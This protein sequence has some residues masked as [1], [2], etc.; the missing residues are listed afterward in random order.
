MYAVA[1]LADKTM[2]Y[3]INGEWRVDWAGEYQL[4]DVIVVYERSNHSADDEHVSLRQTPVDL[5]VFV[6][7]LIHKQSINKQSDGVHITFTVC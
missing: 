4:N 5:N 2:S 3:V 7:I 6:S 1:A